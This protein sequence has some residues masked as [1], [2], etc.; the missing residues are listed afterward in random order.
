MFA[1]LKALYASLP[2]WAQGLVVAIEGGV[3]GFILQ[4]ASDPAPLCFSKACLRHFV[5]A[6]GGVIFMSIRNWLRASPLEQ[7]LLNK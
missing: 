2:S 6:V 7:R 3:V 1:K 5:G 4:W